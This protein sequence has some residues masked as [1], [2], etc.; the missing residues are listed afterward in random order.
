MET[1]SLGVDGI[2]LNEKELQALTGLSLMAL[3]AMNNP[4]FPLLV[5]MDPVLEHAKTLAVVGMASL[6]STSPEA[7]VAATHNLIMG[8][9]G[10]FVISSEITSL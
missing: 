10:H 3:Y 2:H 8:I 1:T 5:A 9:A 4:M 7:C 6:D